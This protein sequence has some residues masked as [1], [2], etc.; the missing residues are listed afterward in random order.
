MESQGTAK[1]NWSLRFSKLL[2]KA[3]FGKA[4]RACTNFNCV[5]KTQDG[6]YISLPVICIVK[7]LYGELAYS[8][9]SCNDFK[10]RRM[11]DPSN[12]KN[13]SLSSDLLTD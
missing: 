6:D 13:H 8:K 2:F 1:S 7:P 4:Q 12:T 3:G 9:T 11:W 5:F 10:V